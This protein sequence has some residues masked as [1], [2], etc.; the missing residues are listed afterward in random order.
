MTLKSILPFLLICLLFSMSVTCKKS[1]S[2]PDS[3]PDTSEVIYRNPAY[4]VEVRVEDLLSRMTL[5]EK[6][7]QMAQADRGALQSESDIKTYFL[8]SILSGGGSAP[9]PN[10]PSEW[11]D[12]Y[13]RFQHLAMSTRLGIPIIYGIDA[14][15]GHNNVYGATI[16]PH[17]IGMGCT[18]NPDLMEQ[19]AR[20]TA[21]ELA[22]TGLDWTFGPCIAVPR[23][24]RWGRTYEG[25]G[26]TPELAVMMGAAAV[27]GFQGTE[28]GASPTS[29]LA[30]AKH[31]V[32]DGGTTG[33]HDQG[34]TEVDE[35]TLRQIHLPGYLAAIQA[36]AGS[37]MVSFSSW[38]GQKMHGNHY[39]LTEV[40]K[41]ELGFD[42]FLVS[43]WAG[44]D[45]LP[46]DYRSDVEISINAGLDMI[47][48]PDKYIQFI[49]TLKDLVGRNRVPLARIDDAVRRILRIKFRMGLFEHPYTD[50]SYT[51]SVGSAAH[52][53]I[54][55]ECVRQSLVLLKNQNQI[56]P[57]SKSMNR[58]HV[59]GK[60]ADNVGNQCG[61]WTISWQ[62][63][64]GNITPG[65]TILQAIQN[66]I[67]G[68]TI[69]TYSYTG[70]NAA[71]ADV[72]IVVIGETPYAEGQGDRSDLHL[73]PEDVAAIQNVKNAGVPVVAVLI[74]GRPM[75]IEPVLELCDAFIAAWLPGTEGRGVADVIF[76][77]YAP[78]GKL[79]HSWPRN[80]AQ[81]P[82]NAG[83]PVYDPLFPYGFGLTY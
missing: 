83:D 1:S 21:E 74:S 41:G 9:S 23:D 73:A 82:V 43:D 65:S 13:D 28:L 16:F 67:T 39:L 42:G 57:L 18:G 32:G 30:C 78:T 12:M 14:V 49:N 25:F 11:G 70:A 6:I 40:L 75:I 66:T 64:S 79:S 26:E 60:S 46:G 44:I 55:R 22:G 77:D 8:G 34:N 47:M 48:V 24:E 38:N 19:A 17:N 37:I 10:V 56:L 81:I 15:H 20:A 3:P 62:G 51:G 71:G 54:A 2:N 58:I 80:M 45:Q 5:E 63:S 7:G 61:G 50:R 53:Q 76:G 4:P 68:N 27:R 36:G 52:R 35:Q 72:G 29:V 33:G 31:F 59:A 69:I